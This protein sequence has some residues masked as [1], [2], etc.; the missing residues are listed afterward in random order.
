MRQ[1]HQEQGGLALQK[2]VVMRYAH[3]NR[4]LADCSTWEAKAGEET[5]N[6]VVISQRSSIYIYKLNRGKG[7][8]LVGLFVLVECRSRLDHFIRQCTSLVFHRYHKMR[9]DIPRSSYICAKQLQIYMIIRRFSDSLRH[10]HQ[11]PI[12]F[13]LYITSP[14][15]QAYGPPPPHLRLH[16]RRSCSHP[17]HP[18]GPDTVLPL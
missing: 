8:D 12:P 2:R 10:L 6:T 1:L 4:N 16:R 11:G 14:T 13:D 15:I 5:W 7:L 3:H 17:Q 18:T 9:Y